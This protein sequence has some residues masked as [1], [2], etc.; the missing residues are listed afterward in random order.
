MKKQSNSPLFS[1][2]LVWIKKE[3]MGSLRPFFALDQYLTYILNIDFSGQGPAP[4]VISRKSTLDKRREEIRTEL[5]EPLF[6][7]PGLKVRF[8]ANCQQHRKDNAYCCV[9]FY[10]KRIEKAPAQN[11]EAI[12]EEFQ[13]D[14]Q[15]AL[16]GAAFPFAWIID[17]RDPAAK[18][19]EDLD[20]RMAEFEEKIRR[21]KD[22]A[23]SIPEL[24]PIE[25]EWDAMKGWTRIQNNHLAWAHR[26]AEAENEI[27]R[28]YVLDV[29][30]M[31][32]LLIMKSARAKRGRHPKE[33]NVLV[34]H[35]IKKC[36]HWKFDKDHKHIMRK[37]GQHRLK[38][39]W[40]LVMF[41]L[42]DLHIHRHE[43][44]ELARFISRHKKDRA[45]VA[46]R[47]LQAWLLNIRKNFPAI[48]GWS[49]NK[50]GFPIPETG[51]RKLIVTK[52]GGLKG[53]Q[54]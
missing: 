9:E 37:D 12:L 32:L 34:Y 47:A 21:R 41:L 49:M 19:Q 22:E 23:T 25:E 53:V 45:A 42:L 44:P 7:L 13:S 40:K 10:R 46:F 16:P 28:Q 11:L 38:T 35:I 24:D 54:L 15:R 8:E 36:T 26:L 20:K 52:S 14:W 50:E 1:D 5:V 17:H 3:C 31:P 4:R 30:K 48:H 6:N 29:C 2:V 27:K 51:F 33:F 39:D 43:L 18:E